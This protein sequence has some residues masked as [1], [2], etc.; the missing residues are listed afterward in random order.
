MQQS[1]IIWFAMAFS[2][3]I[4]FAVLYTMFPVAPRPFEESLQ[5]ILTLVF[6]G[7]AFTSF[8]VGLVVFPNMLAK[9]PPQTKMIV[10][11]AIFESV[12]ICGLLAAF[13][14][15]DWRI[16]VPAWIVSLIGMTRA[17]PQDDQ[18]AA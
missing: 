9:A 14:Q 4:Y 16:Y 1:K 12:A 8:M 10:T 2:T 7:V 11:L 5:N 15:Q 17:F 6:Y 13:L 3:V 18:I